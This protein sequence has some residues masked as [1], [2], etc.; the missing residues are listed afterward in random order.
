MHRAWPKVLF[1][2]FVIC[3]ADG[4]VQPRQKVIDTVKKPEMFDKVRLD[5]D[6]LLL[7]FESS[8]ASI[9]DY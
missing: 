9:E 8:R 3:H 4:I 6:Y 1:L 2:I 7:C 5:V